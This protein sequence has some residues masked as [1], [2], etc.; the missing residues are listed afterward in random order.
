MCC[1]PA[2]FEGLDPIASYYRAAAVG[3]RS[4]QT[5]QEGGFE[6]QQQQQSPAK[7][8]AAKKKKPEPG[9]HSD[10]KDILSYLKVTGNTTSS[11]LDEDYDTESLFASSI[12]DFEEIGCEYKDAAKIYSFCHR[13]G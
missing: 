6:Q 5:A 13:V 9:R 12:E 4:R 1:S 3:Q 2:A 8:K 10:L 11:L 7:K